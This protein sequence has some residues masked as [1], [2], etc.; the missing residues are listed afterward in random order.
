MLIAAANVTAHHGFLGK[1]VMGFKRIVPKTKAE[2]E[3][4]DEGPKTLGRKTQG[5]ILLIDDI[6]D[7]GDGIVGSDQ[8]TKIWREIIYGNGHLVVNAYAGTG[9][10]FTMLRGLTGLDAM[11]KLPRYT[12]VAAFNRAVGKEL[13]SKVP[14]GVRAGTLHSFGLSACYYTN[15][16]FK[17]E[18]DKLDGL[19]T[20]IMGE[21]LSKADREAYYQILKIASLCKNT[22]KGTITCDEEWVYECN[23]KELDDLCLRY[24]IP[25]DR[26][27]FVYQKVEEL[28]SASLNDETYIDQDDMIWLPVVKNFRV[29]QAD[30]LVVDE[31]QDLNACQQQLVLKAG[32][33][34]MLVGDRF[35]AIYG[36]RG[37]DVYSMQTMI[38]LL[39]EKTTKLVTE[40]PLSKTRRCPKSHVAYVREK[41]PWLGEFEALPE[42]PEGVLA[43]KGYEKLV[44]ECGHGDMVVCRTNAPNIGLAFE[45]IR[46][47]KRVKIQGRDI[48][49]KFKRLAE[50]HA[51]GSNDVG[52]LRKNFNNWYQAQLA[53]F[54]KIKGLAKRERMISEMHDTA[55]SMWFFLDNSTSVSKLLE[56]I[57][58]LFSESVGERNF[59]LLGTAHALKGM[60]ATT[61]WVLG[62]EEM[63]HPMARTEEDIEQ[64]WNLWYVA[65]TRSK[66]N[67]YLVTLPERE[68]A[69]RE[70]QE[71]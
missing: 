49:V 4:L 31:A 3:L 44:Q 65:H 46:R 23:N 34:I 50:V 18:P 19:L 30:L 70:F 37:A 13:Q 55:R 40:L 57:S 56:M 71:A 62:P 26:P 36:F 9:K 28:M 47:R 16:D 39:N 35:Q 45:L 60:E 11:G 43:P 52:V 25:V 20:E 66:Q 69:G 59:T 15:R 53:K 24:D 32:R 10:T 64:E 41:C 27:A 14:E 54:R 2:A 5:K 51:H 38:N 29:F 61:V 21:K 42:A 6:P 7:L 58:D 33:R 1:I 48:G 67:L 8:Q 63:P 12:N 17:I 68:V 22:L